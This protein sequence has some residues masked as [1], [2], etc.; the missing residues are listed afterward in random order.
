M[1]VRIKKSMFVRFRQ[2]HDNAQHN[3]AI[4]KGLTTLFFPGI[5]KSKVKR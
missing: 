2:I 4:K 1:C 5:V 3:E